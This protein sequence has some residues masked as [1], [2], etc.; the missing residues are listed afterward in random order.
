MSN[1]KSERK[2]VWIYAV[3]L[4]TSVFVVLLLTAYSQIKLNTNINKYQK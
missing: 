4:F 3:I 2:T 1:N